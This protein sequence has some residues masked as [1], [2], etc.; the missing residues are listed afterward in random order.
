MATAIIYRDS[1]EIATH[2]FPEAA[3]IVSELIAETGSVVRMDE[4]EDSVSIEFEIPIDGD[5]WDAREALSD[6][7]HVLASHG[8]QYAVDRDRIVHDDD[9]PY[10]EFLVHLNVQVPAET[11]TSTEEIVAQVEGALAVGTDHEQT[12]ALAVATVEVALAEE[13]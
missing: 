8:I 6:L 5:L 9:E 4:A 11:E 1:L 2:D 7:E 13:I 12:P 10:R 3:R